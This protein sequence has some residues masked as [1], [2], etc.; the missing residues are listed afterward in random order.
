MAEFSNEKMEVTED[1]LQNVSGGATE[2]DPGIFYTQHYTFNSDDVKALA[3][4]GFKVK[5][6]K[7]YSRN[8]LNT[9]GIPG[10]DAEKMKAN[11]IKLGVK[12]V[13]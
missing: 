9:M 3:K 8:Q 4:H 12:F 7:E 5:A 10:D 11:L 2:R 6:G 1:Q 13:F